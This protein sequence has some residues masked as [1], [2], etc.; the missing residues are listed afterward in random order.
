M[1]PNRAIFQE[2]SP[3][4]QI[5][6]LHRHAEATEHAMAQLAAM[7]ENLQRQLR[8]SESTRRGTGA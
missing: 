7:V 2:M 3:E 6:W 1:L 8:A 4:T 5:D